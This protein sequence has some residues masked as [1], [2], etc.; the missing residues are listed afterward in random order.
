MPAERVS[1]RM[2]FRDSNN[3]IVSFTISPPQQPVDLVDLEAIMQLIVDSNAFFTYTE[4]DVV[5]K[6]DA[7]LISVTDETV[8]DWG[9]GN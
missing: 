1:L 7:Q 3:R 2:R 5:E 4:G 6:L 8:A 9:T